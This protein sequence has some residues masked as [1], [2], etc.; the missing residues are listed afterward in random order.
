[1]K[2][3][4]AVLVFV[5]TSVVFCGTIGGSEMCFTTG[6]LVSLIVVVVGVLVFGKATELVEEGRHV[7]KWGLLLTIRTSC[8]GGG[9]YS[10][11]N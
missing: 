10:S 8:G 9:V 7:Q 11:I 3:F 6:K 4:K 1:M 2:V 5:A